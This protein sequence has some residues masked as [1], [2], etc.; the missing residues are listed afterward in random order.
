MRSINEIIIAVKNCEP[1]TEQELRLCVASLD[2]IEYTTNRNLENLSSAIVE[3]REFS[4]GL[5]QKEAIRWQETRF[6]V[7]KGT[8]DKWL[9]PGNTPGTP[10]QRQ[11]IATAKA[12]FKAATGEQLP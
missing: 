2:S 8:P 12:I 3:G 9:G 6:N 1:A 5:Y 10:E 7:F 4:I 11:R